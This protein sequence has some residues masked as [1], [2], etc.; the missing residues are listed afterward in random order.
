MKCRN[1]R[2]D[3]LQLQGIK[4]LWRGV[5]PNTVRAAVLTSSQI[6]TYDEVKGWL[7]GSTGV[8]EGFRLHLGASMVAVS[9]RRAERMVYDCLTDF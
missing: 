8:Q 3:R 1:P 7:K 9:G 5:A 2:A 4:G 6:A